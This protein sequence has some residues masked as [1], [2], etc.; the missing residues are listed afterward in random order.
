[1]SLLHPYTE[2]IE[3]HVALT[4]YGDALFYGALN[5]H[6]F[7]SGQSLKQRL[8]AWHVPSFYG[9]ELEIRQ[10][11]EVELVVLPAEEVL[12][13]FAS[14]NTLTHIEWKWDEQAAY[15]I[16]LSPML[17]SSIENRKYVPSFEAYRT[18][19]LQWSWDSDSLKKQDLA[20]LHEAFRHTDESYAEGLGAAYSAAVFQQWYSTEE[21]AADLRRSSAA[22]SR[23][24]DDSAHGWS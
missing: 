3:V 18:G 15:L 22:L 10:V 20:A 9:T 7:V 23:A 13:F 4:G 2:T 1:M 24:R 21:A 16:Q 11:E 19:Q 12:L 8:F 14:M 6:H 17:A 5:T